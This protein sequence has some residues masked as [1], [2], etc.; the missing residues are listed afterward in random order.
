MGKRRHHTRLGLRLRPRSSSTTRRPRSRPLPRFIPEFVMG[1]LEDPDNLAQLPDQTTVHLL[2]VLQEAGLRARELHLEFNP[3]IVDSAG[4]PCLKY[5][6]KMSTEQLVPL[7]S[8]LSRRSAPGRTTCT[9]G[10]PAAASPAVSLTGR[11][12]RRDPAVQRRHPRG[13]LVEWEHD[14]GL[15]DET[16]WPARVTAHQ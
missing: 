11:Q 6:T 2:V 1:H 5:Y 14:I 3:I 15:H 12:P 8:E 13:R 7:R 9:I 10:G 16:G 4:W